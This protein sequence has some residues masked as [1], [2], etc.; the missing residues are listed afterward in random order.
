MWEIDDDPIAKFR[1]VR[2]ELLLHSRL[3][4]GT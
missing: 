4:L 2:V 3:S 1:V